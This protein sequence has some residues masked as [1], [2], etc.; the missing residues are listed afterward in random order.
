MT[1]PTSWVKHNGISQHA[2]VPTSAV[3]LLAQSGWERMSDDEVAD[4][5]RTADEKLAAVEAEMRAKAAEGAPDPEQLPEQLPE[6]SSDQT[7]GTLPVDTS[8]T[9]GDT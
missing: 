3:P 8:D 1:G 9:K 5:T 7:A 2:E 6:Q 4:L